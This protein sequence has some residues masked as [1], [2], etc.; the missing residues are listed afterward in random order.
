[1]ASTQL[2][3]FIYPIRILLTLKSRNRNWIFVLLVIGMIIQ[4]CIG[5]WVKESY[6]TLSV[7]KDGQIL[8]VHSNMVME[9]GKR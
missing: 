2:H 9:Y 3:G 7:W 4:K 8:E 6:V 1:M 5:V